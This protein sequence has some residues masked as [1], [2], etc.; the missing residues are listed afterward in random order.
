[1][2]KFIKGRG[3]WARWMDDDGVWSSAEGG[4]VIVFFFFIGAKEIIQRDIDEG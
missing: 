1:M 4:W 3:A 2:G